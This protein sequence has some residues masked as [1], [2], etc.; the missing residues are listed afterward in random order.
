VRL[1]TS[2][3]ISGSLTPNHAGQ[4]IYLQTLAGG[5]WRTSAVTRLSATSTYRFTVR[6]AKRTT[7]RYRVYKPADTDHLSV[8]SGTLSLRAT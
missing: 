1:G 4:V 3:S 7:Y 2:T 8:T 5:V 6:P